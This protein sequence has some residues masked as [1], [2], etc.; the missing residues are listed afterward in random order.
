MIPVG[1][2]LPDLPALANS[3]ALEALNV[4]PDAAS[5]RPLPAFAEQGNAMAARVQGAIYARG[6]GGTI[7][8]FAG[9]GSNLYRWDSSG[10]NW[11]DVSRIAGGAYATPIDGGWSFA[12]FGDLVI[13]ANGADAPQRYTVGSSANFEALAG[14][15][16]IGRLLATVRDFVVMGRIAATVNRVQWSGINNAETWTPSQATQADFQDLPD[17]GSIMGL[18]GG[19]Y[20]VVFQE[21]SI[22]RMTY[23]GVPLVFQIDEIARGIGT[24]AEGSVA[25]YEDMAFFLSDEGFYALAGAQQLQ[26]IGQNKVDRFFWNDVNQSHLH[27][28]SSAVDPVNKLYVVSY[29][30]AASVDGMPD[31]LLI[32]SWQTDR[33]SR[34]EQPLALLHQGASQASY[35]LEGLDSVS[36][37]LDA[38]P[39]S[40]DSRAWTGAGRLLLGG[41]STANRAGF[42]SG[43]PMAAVVDTGESQLLAGSRALVRAVRPLSDGGTPS[44]ALGFRNRLTD[45][46]QWGPDVAQNDRGACPQRASARYFRA[47]LKIPAGQSWTHLQGIDEIDAAPAGR[48]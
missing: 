43:Q 27:R 9:D 4:I 47:R 19:E 46:V 3:G 17:G 38:L 31:K 10:V 36:A 6:V 41:F 28:I 30:S 32:Y 1:P 22:K 25:R 11:Q 14:S 37:S 45:A 18:V 7:A 8:Q 23:V 16:P 44:V 29:P 40:L 13:A 34:A 15:P 24:P 48:Q 5:Y 12:Q 26:G 42:F 21:R 35:T 33:W 39:F 2:W 20:G